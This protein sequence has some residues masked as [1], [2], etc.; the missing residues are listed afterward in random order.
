MPP[1]NNSSRDYTNM[2][3]SGIAYPKSLYNSLIIPG[4]EITVWMRK[5]TPLLLKDQLHRAM[6]R[7]LHILVDHCVLN[8]VGEGA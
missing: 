7:A 1:R 2:S 3:Y 5:I 6:V 8:P 4:Q